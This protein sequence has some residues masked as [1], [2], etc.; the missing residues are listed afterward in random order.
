M[1]NIT[2]DRLYAEEKNKPGVCYIEDDSSPVL[3]E[4]LDNSREVLA[5]LQRALQDDASI[6]PKDKKLIT[7]T[8]N[9]LFQWD[10]Y[11]LYFEYYIPFAL[12]SEVPQEVKRDLR[13]IENLKE[14][15]HLILNAVAKRGQQNFVIENACRDVVG[16][17]PFDNQKS[18]DILV[19]MIQN[20]NNIY[21]LFLAS[22]MDKQD[23]VKEYKNT[24]FILTPENFFDTLT[25]HYSNKNALACSQNEEG[26]WEQIKDEISSIKTNTLN[27]KEGFKSWQE[28]IEL[29][30]GSSKHQL[31]KQVVQDGASEKTN[32]LQ[33]NYDR[34]QDDDGFTKDNNFVTNSLKSLEQSIGE[35]IESFSGSIAE[36]L[37]SG[38]EKVG[39]QELQEVGNFIEIDNTIKSRIYE[40]YQKNLLFSTLEN[41]TLEDI[42]S[43][44]EQLHHHLNDNIE[45]LDKLAPISS[46]VCN[47]QGNNKGGNCGD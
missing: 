10:G 43:R 14:G 24:A 29:A 17:C 38:Q 35:Q 6:N 11:E 33:N 21:K 28:A 27:Y 20:T 42:Q 3:E 2:W 26:F 46:K 41:D 34:Y 15:L 1:G 19:N 5:N 16:N 44:I 31:N 39:I 32:V 7:R 9:R 13:K 18:E 30:S 12:Q 23:Q 47:D 36:T 4:F 22:V 45:T 8:Y 25:L 40:T 37:G